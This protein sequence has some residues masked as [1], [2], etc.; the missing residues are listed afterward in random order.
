MLQ[1]QVI[2]RQRAATEL[3]PA[4]VTYDQAIA[5]SIGLRLQERMPISLAKTVSAC[6][7]NHKDISL[8]F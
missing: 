4:L 2:W 5:G 1:E 7:S 6:M 3:M 8:H